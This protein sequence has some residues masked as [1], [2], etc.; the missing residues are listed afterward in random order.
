MKQHITA[1]CRGCNKEY[2]FNHDTLNVKSNDVI[3]SFCE[4]DFCYTEIADIVQVK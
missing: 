3:K 2:S 1:Q 4:T